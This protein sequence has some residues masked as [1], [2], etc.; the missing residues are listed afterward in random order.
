M[1]PR[2]SDAF[3]GAGGFSLARLA[4]PQLAR[5]IATRVVRTSHEAAEPANLRLRPGTARATALGR[6]AG[7]PAP[8][9]LL[10]GG[11]Q[12]SLV[13]NRDRRPQRVDL[14]RHRQSPC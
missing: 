14:L 5:A 9:R 13:Q 10:S 7:D 8:A 11:V 4:L 1:A 6:S 12:E 3:T 2:A